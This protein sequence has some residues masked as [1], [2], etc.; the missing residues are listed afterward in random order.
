[1]KDDMVRKEYKTKNPLFSVSNVF[2]NKSTNSKQIF[3][4]LSF[5]VNLVIF[6]IMKIKQKSIQLPPVCV[7]RN[8]FVKA[9]IFECKSIEKV[10]VK[11]W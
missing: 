8:T 5:F 9:T 2:K 11:N 7:N 4:R 10:K 6:K 1:M 3:W